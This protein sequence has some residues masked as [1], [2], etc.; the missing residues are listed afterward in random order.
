MTGE[1]PHT[2]FHYY[3]FLGLYRRLNVIV[4]LNDGWSSE[5]GGCLSFY[6]AEGRAVQTVVPSWGRA[7]I[8]RTDDDSVHGFPDPIADGS[9]RRSVALFYYT[10]TPTRAFGGDETTYYRQHGEHAGVLQKGRLLAFRGLLTLSRSISIVA[11]IVN[12]NMG[13][14]S[15]K[16]YFEYRRNA[17]RSHFETA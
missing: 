3:R 17:K 14:P 13:I 4:Y 9:W 2:D 11:H 8:F 12:P 7:V 6:D 15:V 16:A 10:P 5:N 1:P